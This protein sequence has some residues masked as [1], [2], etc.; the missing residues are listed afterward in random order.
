MKLC[1]AADRTMSE[2]TAAKTDRW[3]QQTDRQIT[4]AMRGP[5]AG[6]D[7]LTPFSPL[8]NLITQKRRKITLFFFRFPYLTNVFDESTSIDSQYNQL[9]V[10][11]ESCERWIEP[12]LFLSHRLW[13]SN[14][15]TF[16]GRPGMCTACTAAAAA[17]TDARDCCQK[18]PECNADHTE[19]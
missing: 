19:H 15:Q 7:W 3:Q 13:V 14:V 8:Y 12:P 17:S 9:A 10:S 11:G 18:R 16:R 1:S 4:E 5:G 2:K 6:R